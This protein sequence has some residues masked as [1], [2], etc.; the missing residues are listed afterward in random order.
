V[1]RWQRLVLPDGEE[2][3][4]EDIPDEESLE[5]LRRRR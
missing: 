3:W 5:E 1:I 4:G 2:L